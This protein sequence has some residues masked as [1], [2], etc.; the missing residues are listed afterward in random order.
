MVNREHTCESFQIV[1]E[2][3]RHVLAA[4]HDFERHRVRAFE[5]A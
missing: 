4:I 5:M 3:C 2:L 1:P